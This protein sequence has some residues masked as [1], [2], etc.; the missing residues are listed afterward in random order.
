[1]LSSNVTIQYIS[2]FYEKG[3]ES[4]GI[5]STHFFQHKMDV[6]NMHVSSWCQKKLVLYLSNNSIC[7]CGGYK[8]IQS[9]TTGSL[10]NKCRAF[11]KLCSLNSELRLVWGTKADAC[12]AGVPPASLPGCPDYQRRKYATLPASPALPTRAST[13]CLW[14]IKG[15]VANGL[16]TLCGNEWGSGWFLFQVTFSG[17]W[18]LSASL[19]VCILLPILWHSYLWMWMKVAQYW[20]LHEAHWRWSVHTHVV[21]AQDC[22]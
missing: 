12:L 4:S 16:W 7:P 20:S 17:F 11:V 10:S 22:L 8:D 1:M 18:D 21:A 2:S 14:A 3:T 6:L 5:W 19:Y 13:K 9:H 15:G